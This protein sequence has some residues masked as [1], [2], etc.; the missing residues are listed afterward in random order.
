M[1]ADLELT[2][3]ELAERKAKGQR[4]LDDFFTAKGETEGWLKAKKQD[5][6]TGNHVLDDFF[7]RKAQ[8]EGWFNN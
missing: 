1:N 4:M 6:K 7:D 8:E 2:P 5:T 3:E